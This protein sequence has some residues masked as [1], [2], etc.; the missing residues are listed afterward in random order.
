LLHINQAIRHSSKTSEIM[1]AFFSNSSI[2]S[3]QQSILETGKLKPDN[4][5]I[6]L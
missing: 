1:I 2:V 6:A 3:E 4:M 5:L